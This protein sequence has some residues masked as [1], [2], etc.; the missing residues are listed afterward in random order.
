MLAVSDNSC[1]D[2]VIAQIMGKVPA[3]ARPLE[4]E[5]LVA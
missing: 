4:H 5:K 1:A 2:A 3:P